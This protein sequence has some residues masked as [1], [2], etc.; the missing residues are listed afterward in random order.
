M[1]L[2]FG[3]FQHTC[4][5]F[6]VLLATGEI[7]TC[8][9]TEN[10]ELFRCIPWGHGTLGFLVGAE[11]EIV[12]CKR[13]VRLEYIPIVGSQAGV[14]ACLAAFKG[15]DEFVES[16]VYSRDEMVLMTGNFADEVGEDGV[17]NPIGR[18]YKPWFFTHVREYLNRRERAVE[19]VPLREYYHR[20]TKS[21][22][23]EVQDIITFGNQFWF[24]FLFGWMMP[25]N[26]SILKRTQ[27]EELR[28]L[29]EKH[30]VVQDML[31]PARWVASWRRAG[32]SPTTVVK[33]LT[34]CFSLRWATASICLEIVWSS[35]G[36]SVR[37][38]W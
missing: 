10:A 33:L 6:E 8:S 13:Y 18:W 21:L 23:W 5:S 22:F 11:L 7:V 24:R 34:L 20:H 2:R 3:L 27:T 36:L 4:K 25:P 1:L 32:H 17:F 35:S 12:P 19:Y 28:E 15:D 38:V 26:H 16:L 37:A 14:D 9:R 30:H 29:Y 31:V